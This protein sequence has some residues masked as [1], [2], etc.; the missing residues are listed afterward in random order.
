MVDDS[1]SSGA[2][3]VWVLGGGHPLILLVIIQQGQ[4]RLTNLFPVST[5]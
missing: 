3:S 5:N 4:H 1:L 2:I